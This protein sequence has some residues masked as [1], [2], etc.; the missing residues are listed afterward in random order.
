[1]TSLLP[2]D[3]Y[4]AIQQLI[5]GFWSRTDRTS[6][7]PSEDLFDKGARSR[8]GPFI[9]E[10]HDAITKYNVERRAAE[11]RGGRKVRHFC[12]NMLFEHC[13]PKL[14][15][16][17]VTMLV[18]QGVGELPLKQDLPSTIADFVFE[19]SKGE[20]GSWLISSIDGDLPWAGRPDPSP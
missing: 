8:I 16:L 6:D 18:F 13:E 14:A 15:R 3:D 17:R 5:Q 2:F 9:C 20:S 11:D 7:A 19:V 1:M 10:D 4:I 12:T